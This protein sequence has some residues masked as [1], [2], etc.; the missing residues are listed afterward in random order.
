M[1]I[2]GMKA[3][4]RT[5]FEKRGD[6]FDIGDA[7]AYGKFLLTQGSQSSS[8]VT[9]TEGTALGLPAAYSC[10]NVLSQ[11]LANI[12]LELMKS[13][14][15]KN[16]K[17]A[18]GHP[19]Y[20]LMKIQPA[21]GQ[22]SYTWRQTLEGHRNG[23]GN[24]YSKINRSNGMPVDLEIWLPDRT[25]VRLLDNRARDIFYRS[26]VN[27]QKIEAF[28]ADVLHFK[29]LGFD[30]LIGYS[31]VQMHA[32]AIGLG[33]AI[34]KFGGKFFANGLNPKGVVT[35]P[36][37]Q[38]QL[39]KYTDWLVENFGGLDLAHGTPVL[40]KDMDFK[41]ISINPDDAQTLETLKYNRTEV[42]GIY[43]VPPQ[44][45]MDY[46]FSMLS[47]AKDMNLHF[48]K[49]TMVPIL[50]TWEQELNLKLLTVSERRR[51]YYFRFDVRW[52]MRGDPTE[53][54][55]Y[56]HMALQDGW[57]NRQQVRGWEDLEDGPK[58][59]EE[60]LT[61]TNMVDPNEDKNEGQQEAP[62]DEDDT[63]EE[64]NMKGLIFPLVRS[65]AEKMVSKEDRTIKRIADNSA[66]IANFYEDVY[67]EF[68]RR[69]LYPLATMIDPVLV[70]A[71]TFTERFI[72]TYIGRQL[73][74]S[75][76]PGFVN[77][78]DISTTF[79]EVIKWNEDS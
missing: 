63:E 72:G 40:G 34:H 30:G 38:N 58:E 15:N 43:R 59:L 1:N 51:G 20:D 11:T 12:P 54:A 74:K 23:W 2:R 45:I 6:D 52:F 79:Y 3:F 50:T 32:E 7:S 49:H 48:T 28:P 10:I 26:E 19:I 8:G 64:E 17:P 18:Y 62:R 73:G 70:D 61:P 9:V 22:T 41:P 44:F 47:N 37:S 75:I 31:P 56:Y 46:Q 42:C 55:T 60:Y 78:N 21:D 27:G 36:L 14:N 53:R 39:E 16:P 35:T 29:G 24:A 67:P 25:E 33:L 57:L 71:T 66:K 65:L 13:T 77:E 4:G 5:W 76:A 69:H 68:I